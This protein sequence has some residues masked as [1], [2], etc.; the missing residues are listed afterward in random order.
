MLIP[1]RDAGAT[2]DAALAGLL[3]E[4]DTSREIVAVDDGSTDSGPARARTWAA[5]DSRVRVLAGAGRGLVAALQL[6]ASHA[7]G[8]LLARM[9]ADDVAHPSRLARQRE[10]L[11]AHATIAVLGTQVR[12]FADEGPVG[13]G[14]ARYVAWQNA[15]ITPDEHARERFVESPLCHPSIMMRRAAFEAVG[16]YRALDGPEDYELFL[17]FVAAGHALAKLPEV[18][19]DW[20]HHARRATFGDARYGLAKFR[21]VKAPHLADTVRAAN[22]ARTVMWGAGPTG[23]RLARALALHGLRFDR[24]VDIDPAKIGRTAQGAP[25]GSVDALDPRTDVVV[26][27]VG[28]RGARTLIRAELGARGFVEGESYWFAA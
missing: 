16:G 2:L 6:A 28:A 9:D 18:L 4:A 21:T 13:E 1:F 15:L 22:R 27:A 19:L 26:A 10:Y 8:D 12:A 5:R 25:I 24:F 3:A 7:R 14:L 23:R 20:R 17:R 11:C